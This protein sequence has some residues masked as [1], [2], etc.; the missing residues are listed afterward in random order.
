MEWFSEWSAITN[1]GKLAI[2]G[3][4]SGFRRCSRRGIRNLISADFFRD[5]LSR[6]VS[7]YVAYQKELAFDP[8][9]SFAEPQNRDLGIVKRLVSLFLLKR[10]ALN[11]F[12]ANLFEQ[13][14]PHFKLL[15]LWLRVILLIDKSVFS[16]TC[17]QSHR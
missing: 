15:L 7:F 8:V 5:D 3:N 14:A 17:D 1:L 13:I 12:S 11:C 16:L 9:E 2:L 10:E 4:F 6:Y